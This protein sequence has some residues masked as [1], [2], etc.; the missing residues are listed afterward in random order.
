MIINFVRCIF[1]NPCT[2]QF[3]K[4]FKRSDQAE[5]VHVRRLRRETNSRDANW[6]QRI[7][8]A[9]GRWR[10]Q[11]RVVM[12]SSAPGNR[13]AYWNP[14]V[15]WFRILTDRLSRAVLSRLQDEIASSLCG[16]CFVSRCAAFSFHSLLSTC[17]FS[18]S[19]VSFVPIRGRMEWLEWK[20]ELNLHNFVIQMIQWFTT[21]N[22]YIISF[23]SRI[24][25]RTGCWP[26]LPN[27]QFYHVKQ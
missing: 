3:F 26:R 22:Y 27:I 13:L 16:R 9:L 2:K 4:Q 12:T 7:T 21:G 11:A 6:C 17:D 23:N 8:Q 19:F 18:F 20:Q 24:F 10:G 1:R 14:R 15:L 5:R 25:C